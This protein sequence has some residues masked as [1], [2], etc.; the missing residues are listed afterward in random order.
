[1]RTGGVDELEDL[2]LYVAR[3]SVKR[4]AEV[5]ICKSCVYS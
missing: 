5:A 2:W 1:M 4:S 3:K